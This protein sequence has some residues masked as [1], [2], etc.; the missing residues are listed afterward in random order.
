M[1]GIE[2]LR[3]LTFHAEQRMFT[4]CRIHTTLRFKALN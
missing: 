3:Q 4:E 1:R 2:T